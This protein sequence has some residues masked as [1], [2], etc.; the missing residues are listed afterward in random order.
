MSAGRN[1][2]AAIGV[3]VSLG[4]LIV[5][6]LYFAPHL[7][8]PLVAAAMAVATWEVVKRFRAA[9]TNLELW[10]MLIGG[11][12]II[13]L[14]WPLGTEGVLAAFV[15][16]VL[17]AIVWRLLGHQSTAEPNSFTRDISTTVFVLAWVPLF[18][19]FGAMLVL[20]EDR[21]PQRVAALIIL[22][23]CSDVGGYA[24]GVL[25]G[26]HPM[27]PAISPKKS[28]EGFAGSM[29]AGAVGAVLVL[30]FLLDVN[31][32]WG[33]LLGPVV[34]I[35]A[36]LGDLLESQVKRDLGIKDMGTLLPG[37]GGIMDRLDSLLPSA[38]VVWAALTAL[39][40]S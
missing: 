28:W 9:G 18:A 30:K 3:G 4:A 14:S 19:S 39:M 40:G 34:V 2:P 38:V 1:L 7:W 26:K 31:P 6:I 36:T 17:V 29:V 37:H 22:V 20:P 5:A 33:L 25:F 32:V 15:A 27:V 24:S 21:G 11:Q 23:V 35:T 12:A 16:T 8:V 13:W 10:P